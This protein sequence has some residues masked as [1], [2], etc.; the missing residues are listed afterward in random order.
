MT[1][2]VHTSETPVYFNKT[3]QHSTTSQKAII[4]SK[5]GGE[6]IKTVKSNSLKP[7]PGG[8]T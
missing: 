2:A 8:M 4:V 5:L 6:W 7:N 1:E 3:T